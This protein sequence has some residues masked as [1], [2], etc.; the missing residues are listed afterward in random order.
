M[1]GILVGCFWYVEWGKAGQDQSSKGS[2]LLAS[3]GEESP[4]FHPGP[5]TSWPDFESC[6]CPC[7]SKPNQG[8]SGS[9]VGAWTAG[10]ALQG[11]CLG[12]KDAGSGKKKYVWADMLCPAKL[13]EKIQMS[14]FKSWAPS[15]Q[16]RPLT[17]QSGELC[18]LSTSLCPSV[19]SSLGWRACPACFP[20]PFPAG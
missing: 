1:C 14:H 16:G 3:A 15:G 20:R 18:E 9:R 19:S 2:L 12:S 11:T 5:C 7:R 8:P 6:V 4:A 13:E 10:V 17:Q